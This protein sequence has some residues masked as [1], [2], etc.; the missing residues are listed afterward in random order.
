MQEREP[1]SAAAEEWSWLTGR[2]AVPL[3]VECSP[4]LGNESTL[5]SND[6]D[7]AHIVSDVVQGN[8]HEAVIGQRE[9]QQAIKDAIEGLTVDIK[10]ALPMVEDMWHG[11]IPQMHSLLMNVIDDVETL[12]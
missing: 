1:A 6:A 9:A 12:K 4:L 8:V 7:T 10:Y 2:P 5:T 3:V 11:K